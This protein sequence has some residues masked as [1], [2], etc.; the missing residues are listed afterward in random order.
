[1]KKPAL[2]F[3]SARHSRKTRHPFARPA[4]SILLWIAM[5]TLVMPACKLFT[6]QQPVVPTPAPTLAA[7]PGR[8]AEVA[9]IAKTEQALIQ[10]QQPTP[11]AV[12]LQGA[13]I[14]IS[15]VY[16]SGLVTS[17]YHLYG[18]LLDNFVDV[19]LTNSGDEVASLVVETTIEGYTTAALDTVEVAPGEEV[20]IHQNPRLTQAGVDKLNSQQPGSFH[21]RVTRQVVNGDVVELDE[22]REI[23]LYSRRD[24][25]WISGFDSPEQYEF[26]A[27]WVTPTDPGVEALIRAAAEYS[28]SGMMTNGYGGIQNDDEGK[29]WNRLEALWEAEQNDYRLTYISTMMAF[30]PNTVQRIRL[31]AEVLDQSSGNCIELAALFASAAEALELETAIIR[32]PGHAYTAVRM[33]AENANY[34][35]IET[36]MVGQSSF[37]DAVSY[38]KSEWEEAQP[39]FE[40]NETGYAWVTIQEMREKGILPIPWK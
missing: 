27:A 33:D 31:P 37:A 23:L 28:D 19:T 13:D 1:M 39:H 40:A 34:Y 26:W 7:A 5:L 15:Y 32:I 6:P 10:Q 9:D 38:G 21:I 35:F 11:T 18:S 29:V 14:E 3:G 25:V 36:T 24:F 22:T 8:N 2:F 17:L 16:T 20:E 12:V 30:G 4:F